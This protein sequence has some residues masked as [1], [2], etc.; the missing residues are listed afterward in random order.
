[1]EKVI[2]WCATLHVLV[3]GRQNISNGYQNRI[4]KSGMQEACFFYVIY[5]IYKS[6]K[7]AY[8]SLLVMTSEELRKLYAGKTLSTVQL[9]HQRVC[10][11]I[12]NTLVF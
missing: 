6:L 7:A 11:K 9:I 10:Q 8:M 5:V 12:I 3:Y 2:Y 4:N 1:M